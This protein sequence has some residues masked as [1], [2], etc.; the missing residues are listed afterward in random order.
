LSRAAASGGG[1]TWRELGC[2]LVVRPADPSANPAEAVA[3]R[4]A[5][6]GCCAAA[7]KLNALKKSAGK[8]KTLR[9][10]IRGGHVVLS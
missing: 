4:Q 2:G 8:Q 3:P 6:L 7:E 10:R 5:G 1:A 9:R